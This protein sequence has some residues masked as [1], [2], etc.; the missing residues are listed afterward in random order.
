MRSV[1]FVYQ[2]FF[3]LLFLF[4]LYMT[5]YNRLGGYPVRLFL[6]TNPLVAIATALS[7]ISLYRVLWWAIPVIIL[8]I[9]LGRFYCGWICPLG[10]LQDLAAWFRKST[11]KEDMEVNRYRSIYRLK[12]LILIAFLVASVFGVMQIG[13]IDPIVL[14]TRAVTTSIMPAADHGTGTIFLSLREF[15]LGWVANLLLIG[16]L[17]AAVLRPRLWCKLL[18]PLGALLGLLSRWSIFHIR[19]TQPTCT[20]CEIC[21]AHCQA[22]ADPDREL[23][24]SECMLLFN[25]IET[26][27]PDALTFGAHAP[28]PQISPAIPGPNVTRRRVLGAVLAGLA[29]P[30]FLRTGPTTADTPRPKLIRPPG[31]VP[32]EEFLAR[33]IKCEEC[34][35]VCP[36]NV[37]QPAMTEGGIEALWTPIL[38]N[39]MG[40]C[41]LNCVLCGEVCPTGSIKAISL[42]EKLGRGEFEGQ[43][44]VLG[45]AFFDHGRCLPWAMNR[46]CVV[47]EE[48]CPTSPK[49]IVTDDVTVVENG[50]TIKLKQPR[51]I[52]ELCIG[53]GICEHE[54]P[55]TDQRAIYVTSVGESRSDR[56][57][58]ILNSPNGNGRAT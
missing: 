25:C 20:D 29:L 4:L 39:T 15:R 55:V 11:L 22:S 3:L 2:T 38:I 6:D 53:C 47:C 7:T 10:T 30:A 21:S 57:R 32:E 46:P 50:K 44:V 54:C 1:R 17:V 31:S 37:L 36:T 18:C 27:P 35:H 16:I 45:T 12:Y 23:R 48:V 49:A 5:A 42:N 19:R 40:Y 24:K 26:C 58:M 9:F 28:E 51:V 56:N 43:P 8:T 14:L 33:C 41:E 13:L 34:M 52:P